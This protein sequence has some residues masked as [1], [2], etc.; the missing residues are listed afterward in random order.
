MN[1]TFRNH[2]VVKYSLCQTFFIA[3]TFTSRRFVCSYEQYQIFKLANL[4]MTFLNSQ[5]YFADTGTFKIEV[6]FCPSAV[7]KG[8]CSP[9]TLKMKDLSIL[10]KY[11]SQ[12]ET[13][14]RVLVVHPLE[15]RNNEMTSSVLKSQ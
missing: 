14:T 1:K 2:D 13:N 12:F 7:S 3:T 4:L 8:P 6:V 10:D 11:T 5:I 9:S 15:R